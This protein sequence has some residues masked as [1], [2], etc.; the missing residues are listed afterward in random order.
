MRESNFNQIVGNSNLYK[1]ERS[2]LVSVI[3]PAYN[4]ESFIVEAIDSV[5]AQSYRNIELIIVNDGSTDSTPILCKSYKEKLKLFSQP[6][7]GVSAA[8]NLG[9]QKAKGDFIAFLDA[10]DSYLPNAIAILLDCFLQASAND[11]EPALV[12]GGA[13]RLIN[14]EVQYNTH[15][16][17]QSKQCLDL[18]TFIKFNRIPINTILFKKR[19][20]T[21]L[22][23]FDTN[24]KWRE[25]WDFMLRLIGEKDFFYVGQDIVKYRIHSS[26]ASVN[27]D[28]YLSFH[29][30]NA[31]EKNKKLI[32][33]ITGDR[34]FYSNVLSRELVTHATVISEQRPFT[35]M[36]LAFLAIIHNPRS[37]TEGIKVILKSL[38]TH[39]A[40]KQ[41]F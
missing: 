10:D 29:F 25:D 38:A 11:K 23:L 27:P 5:L 26:Q 34:C 1:H 17:H 6:N 39:V 22:V 31:L 13:A 20:H 37:L 7:Q 36:R 40:R 28:K 8:R 32:T 18:N 16:Y 21:N 3:I 15:D 30:I 12:F 2:Y 24:L 4:A 33:K 19:S 35:S 9:L 41:S 14:S